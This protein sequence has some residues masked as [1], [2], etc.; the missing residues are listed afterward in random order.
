MGDENLPNLLTFFNSMVV[1]LNVRNVVS[2]VAPVGN[3]MEEY[4]V[5]IPFLEPSYSRLL[6]PVLFFLA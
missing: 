5:I 3:H 6:L 2:A 1:V 4:G